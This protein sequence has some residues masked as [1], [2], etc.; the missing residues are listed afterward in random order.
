M[1]PISYYALI[2]GIDIEI[3][4]TIKENDMCEFAIRTRRDSQ[5]NALRKITLKLRKQNI[6]RARQKVTKI[7]ALQKKPEG[8]GPYVFR[9]R[10]TTEI[11]LKELANVE[12]YTLEFTGFDKPI[13]L[14][15][16]LI[17]LVD[18]NRRRSSDR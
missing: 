9:A 13:T 12:I 14:N 17:R 6:K 4:L 7:E 16:N 1:E 8:P 15:V 10:F 11:P 3:E 18:L 2:K 5:E